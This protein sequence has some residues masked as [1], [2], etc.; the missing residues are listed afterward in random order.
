MFDLAC[1]FAAQAV[2]IAQPDDILFVDV[3]V[4]QWRALDEPSVVATYCPAYKQAGRKAMMQ[5]IQEQNFCNSKKKE[6]WVTPNFILNDK[7][8][9]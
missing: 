9:F 2:A 5:L 8:H 6:L 1:Y 7:H 3:D 4:Y